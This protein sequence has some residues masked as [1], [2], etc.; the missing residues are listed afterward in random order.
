MTFNETVKVLLVI[1]GIVGAGEYPRKFK[2][3][4]IAKPVVDLSRIERL[5]G[6]QRIRAN[7]SLANCLRDVF[8][9]NGRDR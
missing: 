4:Y 3:V 2:R 5:S 7:R 6:K 9:H 1:Y 8:C